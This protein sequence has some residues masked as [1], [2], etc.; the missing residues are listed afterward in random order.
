MLC[1]I[2]VA[3]VMVSPHSNGTLTK[4]ARILP[5]IAL[6]RVPG[7]LFWGSLERLTQH[8]IPR[9]VG[10]RLYVEQGFSTFL[11]L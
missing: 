9:P 7:Y 11:M 10:P 2:K 6:G 4:K 8:L 3:L 5:A 1:F